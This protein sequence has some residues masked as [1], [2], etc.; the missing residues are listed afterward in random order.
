[1]MHLS[2]FTC[3][4][5]T[6]LG[7]PTRLHCTCT[8]LFARITIGLLKLSLLAPHKSDVIRATRLA[9]T[10]VQL[11]FKKSVKVCFLHKRSCMWFGC[12]L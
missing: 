4:G 5:W 6:T 11:R 9:H 12:R 3:I 1:M 10:S 2:C 7:S 8:S